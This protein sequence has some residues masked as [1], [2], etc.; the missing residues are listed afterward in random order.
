MRLL[1]KEFGMA[2]AGVA[3]ALALATPA[4]AASAPSAPTAVGL[5]AS[6]AGIAS[7]A[8][9]DC[10]RIHTTGQ[11]AYTWC[12]VYRGKV[13]LIADCN[14]PDKYSN[15][16]YPKAGNPTQRLQAGPCPLGLGPNSGVQGA[17]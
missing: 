16:I 12:R 10:P 17:S 6:S 1:S 14:G 13:R 15:W 9:Y 2:A 7:P 5:G 11:Y 4:S 3:A 8:E